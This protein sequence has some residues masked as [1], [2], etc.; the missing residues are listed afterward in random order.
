M[1]TDNTIHKEFCLAQYYADTNDG[2]EHISFGTKCITT[3]T[4]VQNSVEIHPWGG[5]WANTWNMG[6]GNMWQH[7]L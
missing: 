4:A 2:T 3:S 6:L 1:T 7:W 5:F